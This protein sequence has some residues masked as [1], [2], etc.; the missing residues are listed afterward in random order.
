MVER[1]IESVVSNY[2][3]ETGGYKIEFLDDL[4]LTVKSVTLTR[5]DLVMIDVHMKQLDNQLGIFFH[6]KQC[7]NYE[8]HD[9]HIYD[10]ERNALD[11]NYICYGRDERGNNLE[12]WSE[13][14]S[15]VIYDWKH[16]E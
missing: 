3:L 2:D 5:K 6:A 15:E 12:M 1:K 8:G 9:A 10:K 4:G 14:M 13:K 16:K 11:A 7:E